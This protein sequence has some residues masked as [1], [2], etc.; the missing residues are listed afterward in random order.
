MLN[1]E[2]DEKA[3]LEH[4]SR[5]YLETKAFAEGT[6]LCSSQDTAQREE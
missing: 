5:K 6:M 2:D 1:K 3:R 4:T